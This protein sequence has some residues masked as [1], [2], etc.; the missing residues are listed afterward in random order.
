[1]SAPI[2]LQLASILPAVQIHSADEISFNGEPVIRL[3]SLPPLVQLPG[4]PVHPMSSDPMV[5]A[6][7]S[8]LYQRCYSHAFDQK[9]PVN[10]GGF[11]PDAGLIGRLADANCSEDRWDPGWRIERLEANG[12]AVVCKGDCQRRAAPGEY[13][14]D[15]QS[16]LGSMVGAEVILRVERGSEKLQPGFYFM[17]G[18]TPGDMWDEHF[19]VRFYFNATPD[20]AVALVSY[21]SQQLNHYEIP[22]RM[23][24]LTV[25]GWYTRSDSMVLY[26][27]RRDAKLTARIVKKMPGEIQKTLASEIPLFTKLIMPGVGLAEDPRTGESFGMHRCRLI[28][29][30]IVDAFHLGGQRLDRRVRSVWKRFRLNGL[31]LDTPYLGA[32]SIDLYE[33]LEAAV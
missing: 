1:M 23:K 16:H 27:S 22:Y 10:N 32:G 19:I 31:N 7:Q 29:E 9:G 25:P 13:V 21:L 8:I 33:N 5:R 12:Q 17:F 15:W 30:G 28:A 18:E 14:L 2:H 11:A 3:S 26:I 20:G 4:H 6:I 24:A